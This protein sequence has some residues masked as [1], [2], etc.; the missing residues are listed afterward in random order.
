MIFACGDI[1]SRTEPKLTPVATFEGN[2]VANYVLGNT[3]EKN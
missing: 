3:K 2:Y 1:I